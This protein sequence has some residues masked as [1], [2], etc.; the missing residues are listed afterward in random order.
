MTILFKMKKRKLM[1]KIMVENSTGLF[2]RKIFK[3][4]FG[5]WW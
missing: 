1:Q 5:N 3:K 4:Y 2:L